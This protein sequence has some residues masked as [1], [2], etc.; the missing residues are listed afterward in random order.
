MYLHI[1]IQ[2]NR[3]TFLYLPV[4]TVTNTV[5]NESQVSR[6]KHRCFLLPGPEDR[7]KNFPLILAS[8]CRSSL[9]DIYFT[10]FDLHWFVLVQED[11]SPPAGSNH[12]TNYMQYTTQDTVDICNMQYVTHNNL[13]M[14]NTL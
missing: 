13:H 2:G 11:S 12:R 14:C 6:D 5:S 9:K 1:P 4:E 7:L 10:C 3:S 8:Y